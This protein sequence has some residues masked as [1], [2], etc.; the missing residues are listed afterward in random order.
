MPVTGDCLHPVQQLQ[1]LASPKLTLTKLRA[2]CPYEFVHKS[3]AVS[4]HLSCVK[5]ASEHSITMVC[6]TCITSFSHDVLLGALDVEA[7][8]DIT[9]SSPEDC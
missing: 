1:L 5:T 3:G 6:G 4:R 9:M 7:D 8:W 2:G